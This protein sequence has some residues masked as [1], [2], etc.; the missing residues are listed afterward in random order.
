MLETN[1]IKRI[2]IAHLDRVTEMNTHRKTAIIVGVLFITATVTSSLYYVF[3]APL[4]GAPD[5]LAAVDESGKVSSCCV[6]PVT[7]GD[8]NKESFHDIWNGSR[9]ENL[10]AVVNT[11]QAPERCRKCIMANRL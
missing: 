9:F 1:G 5:Y 7:L 6:W 2:E 11:P 4:L 10:R 3:A 8:L